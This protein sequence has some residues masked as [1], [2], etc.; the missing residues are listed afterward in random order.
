MKLCVM[1]VYICVCVCVSI[2]VW[3]PLSGSMNGAETVTVC[4]VLLRVCLKLLQI[5]GFLTLSA[6]ATAIRGRRTLWG[7]GE[8]QTAS[9]QLRHH[10][11]LNS[12]RTSPTLQVE[13]KIEFY[14]SCC[15]TLINI[16]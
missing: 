14:I 13:L 7:A 5:G 4:E 3:H 6:T 16:E 11:F 12:M 8:G 2:S 9:P 15:S 1:L 10:K